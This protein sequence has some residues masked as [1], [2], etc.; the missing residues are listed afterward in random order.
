M[1]PQTFQPGQ[2]YTTSW[3]E[4]PIH[5]KIISRTAKSAKAHVTAFPLTAREGQ[6]FTRKINFPD[7][8]TEV[9]YPLGTHICHAPSI[10]AVNI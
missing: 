9:I 1:K 6:Q 7:E 5:V 4:I 2:E 10:T 3:G 8:G